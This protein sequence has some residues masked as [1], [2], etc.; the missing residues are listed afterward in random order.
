MELEDVFEVEV[1]VEEDFDVTEEEL[2]VV[3][4]VVDA[5]V[6]EEDVAE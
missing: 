4:E 5:F 2:E 3:V 1:E 6:T